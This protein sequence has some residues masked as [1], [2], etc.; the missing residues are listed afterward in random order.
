VSVSAARI[1][2]AADSAHSYHDHRNSIAWHRLVIPS[3]HA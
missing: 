3:T 2:F 1:L